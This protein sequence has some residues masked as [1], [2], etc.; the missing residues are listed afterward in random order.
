MHRPK[1]RRE[2]PQVA[3]VPLGAPYPIHKPASRTCGFPQS[4]STIHAAAGLLSPAEISAQA[5]AAM[6]QE[7]NR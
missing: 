2:S 4:H 1:E 3:R 7:F 5:P 6:L